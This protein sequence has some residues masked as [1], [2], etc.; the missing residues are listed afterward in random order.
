[1]KGKIRQAA[2][3]GLPFEEAIQE[4][5]VKDIMDRIIKINDKYTIINTIITLLC[6]ELNLN[7]K[8]RDWD[9]IGQAVANN[10]NEYNQACRE[11]Q[12]LTGDRFKLSV[13][14]LKKP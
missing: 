14:D 12:E 1:M 3:A 6:K 2:K 11:F 8:E 7:N 9:I 4:N 10:Y 13:N 5:P